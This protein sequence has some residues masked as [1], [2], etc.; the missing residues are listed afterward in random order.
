MNGGADFEISVRRHRFGLR[1]S[2]EKV[3]E[4][5][6]EKY[7]PRCA[8]GDGRMRFWVPRGL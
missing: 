5:P 2:E 7:E 8:M 1:I 4:P 6:I 3:A